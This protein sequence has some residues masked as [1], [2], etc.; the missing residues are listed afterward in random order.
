MRSL[1]TSLVRSGPLVESV[2]RRH[3]LVD[4]SVLLDF[5]LRQTP[6]R[7]IRREQPPPVARQGDVN[8]T[9]GDS[10]RVDPFEVALRVV[11]VRADFAVGF[12]E[13][14][15]RV[16][17][18]MVPGQAVP[19]WAGAAVGRRG[20]VQTV[21]VERERVDLAAIAR[22]GEIARHCRAAVR[23]DKVCKEREEE[24]ERTRRFEWGETDRKSSSSVSSPAGPRTYSHRTQ[25]FR[26]DDK[27]V[28]RGRDRCKLQASMNIITR[29]IE[30]G[31]WTDQSSLTGTSPTPSSL[32]TASK[33]TLL[34]GA[35]CMPG[36]DPALR[37]AAP[38]TSRFDASLWKVCARRAPRLSTVLGPSGRRPGRLRG[39]PRRGAT[40]PDGVRQRV[41]LGEECC[42]A[43]REER[44]DEASGRR[45]AQEQDNHERAE[46][47]EGCK[48]SY[49]LVRW[50]TSTDGGSADSPADP[51]SQAMATAA[52]RKAPPPTMTSTP[53][54]K[55]RKIVTG[56]RANAPNTPMRVAARG[57]CCACAATTRRFGS[58]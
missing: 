34:G 50:R 27:Q 1:L 25:I 4:P 13:L 10:T 41:G 38:G 11:A 12:R 18:R 17:E 36:R 28:C 42:E 3:R 23:F 46:K 8:R 16:Q 57:A 7:V 52:R 29:V 30:C 19:G 6:A 39:R 51:M 43:V 5:Q 56:T 24:S 21:R 14:G 32:T 58:T 2:P 40:H 49:E 20:D 15:G 26:K 55:R 48:E 35:R 45:D 47:Q 53:T 9:R 37:A 33:C 44:G 31:F 22:R 54:A